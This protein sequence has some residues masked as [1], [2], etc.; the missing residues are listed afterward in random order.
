MG[1]IHIDTKID[2]RN[3]VK[4]AVEM[5]S[6][7]IT[8]QVSQILVHPLKVD[9]RGTQPHRYDGNRISPPFFFSE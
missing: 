4:H 2:G 1:E 9:R 6:N 5:E 7:A 8:Y 3:F